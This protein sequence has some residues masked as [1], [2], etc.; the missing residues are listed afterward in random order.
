MP[1]T[2]ERPAQSFN[3]LYRK[4]MATDET[5]KNG[6]KLSRTIFGIVMIC[7]YIGM[8]ILMFINFF[9]FDANWQWLRWVGGTIFVLYGI[10]RG[11]RQFYG[12]DTRA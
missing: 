5:N 2:S 10:W 8:G 12:L 6:T 11:I 4:I 3:Y 9:N 1:V 7:V